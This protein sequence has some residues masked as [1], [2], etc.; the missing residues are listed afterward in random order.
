MPLPETILTVVAPFRPLFT[1][2]TWRKLM[3][4]LT[5]TLLAH[6]RRTVCRALRFSGE[7][8]NGHW[9]LYHQVLNRARWS[10]LA[11]SQ[12]LLL[13]IIETLLPPGACIQIVIDETLERRWGPQ[14]SK[15]GNYRDSALSSRKREVG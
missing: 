13:L 6:G 5:G 8:N 7:Q 4:L 1:A 2:P 14:I 9:S 11:A 3:T 12:C 15:R 10:P